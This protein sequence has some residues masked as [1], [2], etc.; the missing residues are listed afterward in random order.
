T[1]S[2]Q[3]NSSCRTYFTDTT[4]T[5]LDKSSGKMYV[6]KIFDWFAEDFKRVGQEAGDSLLIRATIS[7]KDRAVV[8]FIAAFLP[9]DQADEM[10]KT[11]RSVKHL[12]YDWKLNDIEH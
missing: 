1:L 5:R 3:L 6:S 8:S 10:L 7:E 11:V 9:E 12:P 2:E 4:L